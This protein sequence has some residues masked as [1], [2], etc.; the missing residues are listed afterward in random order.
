MVTSSGWACSRLDDWLIS[1]PFPWCPVHFQGNWSAQ[2]DCIWSYKEGF[3]YFLPHLIHVRAE[4]KMG[5]LLP[6]CVHYSP[7]GSRIIN[8][9]YRF[10]QSPP[11][12]LK[13]PRFSASSK[14]GFLT[15]LLPSTCKTR[16]HP[17]V[18]KS[19]VIISRFCDC[20][21]TTERGKKNF[22]QSSSHCLTPSTFRKS[23]LESVAH[24]GR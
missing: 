19:V 24:S 1:L 9:P 3:F 20:T 21:D 10:P 12:C 22:L 14:S 6:N 13:A 15:L 23:D 7:L 17:S 8:V 18:I 5:S 4:W 2:R 16:A 11:E